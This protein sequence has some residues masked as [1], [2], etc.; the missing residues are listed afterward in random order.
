MLVGA[1]QIQD[2]SCQLRLWLVAWCD[3]SWI[4]TRP[5]LLWIR[6][7]DQIYICTY[8][9]KVTFFYIQIDKV[10]IFQY[11]YVFLW[12]EIIVTDA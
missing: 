8:F 5:V 6:E 4:W 9:S 7:F 1:L 11:V 2:R 3:Q 12:L 10:N